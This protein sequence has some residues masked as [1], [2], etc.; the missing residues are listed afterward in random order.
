MIVINPAEQ[1]AVVGVVAASADQHVGE[2]QFGGSPEV[3]REGRFGVLIVKEK[4]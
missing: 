3:I 2:K 4:Y 1:V